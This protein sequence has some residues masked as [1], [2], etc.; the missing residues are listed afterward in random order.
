LAVAQDSNANSVTS[1]PVS[2]NVVVIPPTVISAYESF[3]YGSLANGTASTATGFTGNWT[4]AGTANIIGN[5]GYPALPTLNSAF[6]QLPGGQRNQVS[7]G[8]TLVKGTVYMSFLYNQ[9]GNNGGNINGL[10][11]PGS[12]ATSLFVG[13]TG[14]WSGTEG[15]LGLG[16]TTTA[17]GAAGISVLAEMPGP[18]QTMKYNQ[19]MTRSASGSTRRLESLRLRATS[20]IPILIWS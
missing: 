4:I 5:L 13:L 3:N 2:I 14:P 15:K 20:M 9:T 12:G 6:E 19:T 16:T 18:F 10:Y 17:G 7:L 1:A 11:L 8:T